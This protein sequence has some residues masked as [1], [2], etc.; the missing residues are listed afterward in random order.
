MSLTASERQRIEEL[1]AAVI[2]VAQAGV[3]HHI[4]PQDGPL[5]EVWERVEKHSPPADD[6]AP[7]RTPFE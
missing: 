3:C 5:R 1:E 6:G 7:E 4:K 2:L